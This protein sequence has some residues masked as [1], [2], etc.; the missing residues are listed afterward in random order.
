MPSI[1]I[2]D[3]AKAFLSKYYHGQKV[4]IKLIGKRAGEKMHEELLDQHFE[5]E[6]MLE[7]KNLIIAIP[8]TQVY[9]KKNKQRK[10]L[11][12]KKLSGRVRYNSD[13]LL[14]KRQVERLI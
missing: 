2:G 5:I 4:K 11:G 9:N 10:Y 12:F 7:N 14:D 8:I 1:K 6:Q 13:N 3:L